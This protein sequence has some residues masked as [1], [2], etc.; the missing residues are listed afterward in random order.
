MSDR[1]KDN[2]SEMPALLKKKSSRRKGKAKL[3]KD[4]DI[5]KFRDRIISQLMQEGSQYFF[6]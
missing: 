1:K 5:K 3:E 4:F 6:I 2:D